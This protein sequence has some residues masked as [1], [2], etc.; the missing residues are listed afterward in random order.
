MQKPETLILP[1]GAPPLRNWYISS[2]N[3]I[4]HWSSLRTRAT[5]ISLIPPPKNSRESY[6]LQSTQQRKLPMAADYLA[7][8]PNSPAKR[9][10]QPGRDWSQKPG[11]ET[12]PSECTQILA[13]STVSQ[14]YIMPVPYSLDTNI[15]T[16]QWTAYRVTEV[17]PW[18]LLGHAWG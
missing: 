8:K 4:S 10:T 1:E 14:I 6:V 16:T 15:P 13:A 9:L 7:Q 11:R 18:Q 17:H 5:L 2:Q 3:T 12:S